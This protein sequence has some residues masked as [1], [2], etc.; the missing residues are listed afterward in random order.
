MALPAH[1]SVAG[2]ALSPCQLQEDFLG[3]VLGCLLW[4]DG[5]AGLYPAVFYMGGSHPIARQF[6]LQTLVRIGR[7]HQGYVPDYVRS[8][9]SSHCAGRAKPVD[10]SAWR[11]DHR[12][13]ACA[14][15]VIS[16]CFLERAPLLTI[17]MK[18]DQRDMLAFDHIEEFARAGA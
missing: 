10:S 1:W 16:R 14:S 18:N 12:G 3:P 8:R 5:R 6:S 13:D 2:P 15:L 9:Y 11:R 7:W 17:M 4:P